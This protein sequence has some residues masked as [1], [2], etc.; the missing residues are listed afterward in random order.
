MKTDWI[1]IGHHCLLDWMVSVVL[2]GMEVPRDY[3]EISGRFRCNNSHHIISID[4]S[5]LAIKR[6][7]NEENIGYLPITSF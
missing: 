4:L 6:K 3:C 5:I 1:P 2:D 7:L